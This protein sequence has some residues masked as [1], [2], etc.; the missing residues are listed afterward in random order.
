MDMHSEGYWVVLL[1]T[2]NMDYRCLPS[3]NLYLLP[4]TNPSGLFVISLHVCLLLLLRG[5]IC[6]LKI[7]PMTRCQSWYNIEG[8]Y[9]IYCMLSNLPIPGWNPFI[10]V[11]WYHQIKHCLCP[12]KLTQFFHKLNFFSKVFSSWCVHINVFLHI[13]WL[14]PM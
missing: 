4:H 10:F 6:F 13:N 1:K 12:P 8:L 14:R 11:F 7:I 3:T 9:I 2:Y 5:Y